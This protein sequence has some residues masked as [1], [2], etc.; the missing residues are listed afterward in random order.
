[1]TDPFDSFRTALDSPASNAIALTPDDATDLPLVCRA[2]NVAV[3]GSVRVT[4]RNGDDVVLTIAAGIPFPI[5][6]KRV[7][8]TGT[9]ASGIVAL[10]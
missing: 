2:L 10:Y 4:T 7:W 8:N 6:V 1:M 3:S 5:R 9:S